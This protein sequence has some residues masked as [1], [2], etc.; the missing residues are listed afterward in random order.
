M[1]HTHNCP[2]FYHL[3]YDKIP[4]MWNNINRLP[5][6]IHPIIWHFSNYAFALLIFSLILANRTPNLLRPLSMGLRFGFGV[7]LLISILALY[8]AF[9]LQ[10]RWGEFISLNGVMLLFALGLAGLWAS[11]ETHSIVLNGL[12]PLSD[13]TNYYIDSIRI[14]HGIDISDFSAM[15]PFFPGFLS[16]VMLLTN[17]NLLTSLGILTAFGGIAAYLSAREIQ[18]THGAGPAVFFLTL[19]FLY[20]RHHSGTTMSETLGVPVSLL[21]FAMMWRGISNS[22]RNLALFGILLTTLALNIRPGAMFVLPAL[23]LWGALIF[24]DEKKFSIRFFLYGAILIAS[25]FAVNKLMIHL[26]AGPGKT[27]FSNFS[28]ALFGLVSGGQ[29]WNYIFTVHP[30]ILDQ[31]SNTA[32]YKLILEQFLKNPLLTVQGAFKYWGMFFSSTWYNA[33]SFVAGSSYYVNE[34]ARW[35]MYILGGIGGIQ[36]LKNRRDPYGSLAILGGL[37][38]LASVPFV[39]P[40]DAYRV[41]L[42]AATIPFIVMLPSLGVAS[43]FNLIGQRTSNS[44]STV[45]YP[46][47]STLFS[48]FLVF[49]LL[50]FPTL[51]KFT[52]EKPA[53]PAITCPEDMAVITFHLNTGSYI[54]IRRENEIFMDW[55][56]NFHLTA[57]REGSH[58]LADQ[59]LT[60]RMKTINPPSTIF[61]VLDFNNNQPALV[62]ANTEQMPKPGTLVHACGYWEETPELKVYGIFDAAEL[63]NAP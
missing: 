36:W 58:A 52:G 24:S 30:E 48:T 12:I 4:L 7:V 60:A 46:L 44:A 34:I 45:G 43:L 25:V 13:A 8:T 57:F 33:Y 55:M 61:Y 19:I 51:I 15:R 40:T 22:S 35:S 21:G 39:P 18:R 14:I 32:I 28:W 26:L 37:G 29:S 63:H 16:V 56:P 3:P 6:R 23:L 42:Y 2:H 49:M 59:N 9:R 27:A 31:G 41:R 17:S 54:N 20:Y 5:E 47:A 38:V 11:G 62:I 10:G 53:A 50:I 1:E